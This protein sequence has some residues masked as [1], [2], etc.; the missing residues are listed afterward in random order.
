M[1]LTQITSEGIKDGEIK[2]VDVNTSAAIAGSKLAA[3]TTSAAGSMSAADKTKLDGVATS[4]TANPSAPALTG[5]TNNTITTV[6]GANAIQ[7]EANLTFDGSILTV[8]GELVINHDDWDTIRAVNTN[9]DTYGAYLVLAKK[10]SSPADNDQVGVVNFRGDNDAG[11]EL[12]FGTIMGK[13]TDVTD[14]TEDGQLEF[15]T[16]GNG[17]YAERLCIKSDGKIGLHGN[18]PLADLHITTAGSSA[19][20]GVLQLGGSGA[21]L[22]LK[23]EYDQT[24]A[25]T[26]KITANPTYNNTSAQLKLSV[27]GDANADQLV[28]TGDGNVKVGDGNLVIGTAGHGIDFSAT[29]EGTAGSMAN[30]LLDDYEEGTWTPTYQD[31]VTS[32]SYVNQYGRYT[33]VGRM[34]TIAFYVTING[35]TAN[36]NQVEFGGIPYAPAANNL[37]IAMSG[38]NNGSS[39]TIAHPIPIMFPGSTTIHYYQQTNTTV[40]TVA[41]TEMGNNGTNLWWATYQA[42]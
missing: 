23:I 26:S 42:A 16:V 9:A 37:Y 20:N 36:S 14:G 29:G 17:T 24:G 30:E 41:G 11:E 22:G 32:P 39:S 12:T 27:D 15:Y 3:A 5:S 6:T 28:L 21:E 13:S 35:G 2:D 19:Q 33:K 34:V 7:G 18:T 31:G 25:T 1:A 4:A 8:G 40:G 38:Y 10:S